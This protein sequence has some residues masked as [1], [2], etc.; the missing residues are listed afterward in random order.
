MFKFSRPIDFYARIL[1]PLFEVDRLLPRTLIAVMSW[2]HIGETLEKM[3]IASGIYFA[4]IMFFLR[5]MTFYMHQFEV[6]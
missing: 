2:E 1:S 4:N 6:M 5:T 3:N